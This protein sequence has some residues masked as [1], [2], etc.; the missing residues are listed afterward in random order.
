MSRSRRISPPPPKQGQHVL[1][2]ESGDEAT[3]CWCFKHLQ[4]GY[5]VEDLDRDQKAALID[6]LSKRSHRTWSEI[7]TESRTK[8]GSEKIAEGSIRG[9]LP[10]LVRGQTILCFRMG[11]SGRFLGVRN[12]QVFHLVWIDCTFS[13]YEH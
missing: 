11:D 5:S 9:G 2:P 7:K 4:K 1:A 3:P 12:A 8:L 10:M 6:S 13:L